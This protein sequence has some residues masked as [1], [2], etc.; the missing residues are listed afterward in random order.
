M[1]YHNN[2]RFHKSSALADFLL[3]SIPSWILESS[4]KNLTEKDGMNGKR[5]G[6][7]NNKHK[8]H[9]PIGS[10]GHARL[11]F[12]RTWHF[13]LCSSVYLKCINQCE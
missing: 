11:S 7:K 9:E 2:R 6:T 3:L 8:V 12:G 10:T 1:N 13:Q 4:L 5:Q